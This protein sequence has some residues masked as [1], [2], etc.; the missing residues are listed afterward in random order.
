M[1]GDDRYDAWLKQAAPKC[2]SNDDLATP[3]F[4]LKRAYGRCHSRNA[5]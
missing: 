2:M 1:D 5:R 4:V 3:R